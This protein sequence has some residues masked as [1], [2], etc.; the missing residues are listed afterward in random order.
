MMNKSMLGGT[1]TFTSLTDYPDFTHHP[2][3]HYDLTKSLQG[4]ETIKTK[5][6]VVLHEKEVNSFLSATYTFEYPEG[7]V[8]EL[9]SSQL[10][11]KSSAMPAAAPVTM[12]EIRLNFEGSIKPLILRHIP[13][14]DEPNDSSGKIYLSK[15]IFE[16]DLGRR[17]GK[18]C[19]RN[20]LDISPW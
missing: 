13:D 15:V 16:R 4:L 9:C 2:N 19:W 14:A 12:A 8:G 18:L 1:L 11:V 5:P 10:A 20:K 7:K 3:W 17:A 6:T